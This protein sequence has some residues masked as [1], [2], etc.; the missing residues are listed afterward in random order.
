MFTESYWSKSHNPE[1]PEAGR[2]ADTVQW[3]KSTNDTGL[4]SSEGKRCTQQARKHDRE[5]SGEWHKGHIHFIC[6]ESQETQ[7]KDIWEA[8]VHR[9]FTPVFFARQCVW[10]REK[11]NLISCLSSRQ[12]CSLSF[13]FH[14]NLQRCNALA[15]YFSSSAAK[16]NI[17]QI[18][19]WNTHPHTCTSAHTV[20]SLTRHN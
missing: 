8:I 17:A 14:L 3:E 12:S 13:Q 9:L 16:K 10:E 1:A 18:W 6:G 20:S 11:G 2:T 4:H 15:V 5:Q 19:T 7:Y